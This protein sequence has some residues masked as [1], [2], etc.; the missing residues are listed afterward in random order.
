MRSFVSRSTRSWTARVALVALVATAF[1]ACNDGPALTAVAP[2]LDVAGS[3]TTPQISAL[4]LSSDSVFIGGPAVPFTATLDNPGAMQSGVAIQGWIVQGTLRHGANGTVINCG[5]G[6][7]VLP[8]GTCTVSFSYSASNGLSGAGTLV[9]GAATFELDLEDG[10]GAVESTVSVPVT[11]LPDHPLITA[12][13]FSSDT[14]FIDGRSTSYT[15][16]LENPNG[17]HTGVVIQGWISQGS[18][19]HAAGGTVVNCG[20]GSGVLPTGSCTVPFGAGASN[21][22]RSGAGTLVPGTATFLLQLKD[23]AGNIVDTHTRTITL[24]PNTPRI[25]ALSL[26][27]TSAIIDGPTV[28]FTS[29][30]DNPGLASHSEVSIQGFVVQGSLKRPANGTEID[31]G[32][33]LGVLP[34]NSCTVSFELSASNSAGGSGT[35]VPGAATFELDLRD[36]TGAVWSTRTVAIT[37]VPDLRFT[38]LTLKSDTAV[39]GGPTVPYSTTITNSGLTNASGLL[40]KSRILQGSTIRAANSATGVEIN[41]GSGSGVVPPGTCTTSASYFASNSSTGSGILVPGAAT[42]QLL[43]TDSTGAVVDSTSTSITLVLPAVSIT[44]LTLSADTVVIGG[45]ATPY[46][47]TI[48]NTGLTRQFVEVVSHVLQGTAN[49]TANSAFVNCTGSIGVLPT[50]TC[51]YSSVFS[52]SNSASG[53]GTLVAGPATLE[54]DV[55]DGSTGKVLARRTIAIVLTTP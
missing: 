29:T 14:V 18:V 12:I 44:S 38:G 10:T 34:T 54:A 28:P 24:Q 31:C 22:G 51:K 8:T 11:L 50:G 37:L 40:L 16:A 2:R 47:V 32:R 6:S 27:S 36:S 30:L 33:G 7:G 49:R 15:A 9:P 39:I 45:T 55:V 46:A 4:T 42:F 13:D 19:T 5:S 53:S 25:T 35:L 20:Q 3:S 48:N 17:S 52:A 21:D 23:S 26:S 43:L 1:S 41:C